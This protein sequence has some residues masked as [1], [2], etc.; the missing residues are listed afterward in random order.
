MT[1]MGNSMT[2]AR[3]RSITAVCGGALAALLLVSAGT[4]WAQSAGP[5]TQLQIKGGTYL[6]D[7]GNWYLQVSPTRRFQVEPVEGFIEEVDVLVFF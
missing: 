7:N 4:A 1:G 5:P 3:R 2:A 6:R